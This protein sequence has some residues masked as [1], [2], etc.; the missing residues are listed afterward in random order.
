VATRYTRRVL[1]AS[2]AA[3]TTTTTCATATVTATIA[4]T[5]TTA[6]FR[7]AIFGFVDFEATSVD[8]FVIESSDGF[9]CRLIFHFDETKAA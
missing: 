9:I 8:L 2:A 1:P 7:R 3:T 4:T 6:I 5:I